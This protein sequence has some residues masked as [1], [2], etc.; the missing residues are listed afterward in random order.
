MG[1]F[2]KTTISVTI[3]ALACSATSFA[4][5][6]SAPSTEVLLKDSDRARGAVESGISWSTAVDTVDGKTVSK[7]EYVIKSKG[8]KAVAETTAP[9][10]AKGEYLIFKERNLWYLKP[11]MK[12]AVVISARQKL[13]GPASNADI[14]STNYYRDY[15]GTVVGEE[16]VDGVDCWKLELKS[17]AKNVSYNGIRY[18]ISKADHLGMKAD[19]LSVKGEVFKSARFKYD[20]RLKLD[21]KDQHFVSEMLIVDSQRP[22]ST[23]N[24]KVKQPKIIDIQDG[25]LD[26]SNFKK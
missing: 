5:T 15:D 18:W 6:E 13:T 12:R 17:K 16:K 2:A 3:I 21:K 1:N 20:N 23:T 11:G 4:A 24:I 10:S 9:E 22:D 25:T 8:D 19:F 14:A 26:L 7:V